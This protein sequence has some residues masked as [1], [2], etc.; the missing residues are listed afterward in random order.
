MYNVYMW[1]LFSTPA[2]YA[3]AINGVLLLIALVV[4]VRAYP[5]LSTNEVLVA[6]LLGSIA[7]G[8]HGISHV[9]V[10]GLLRQIE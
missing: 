8:I 4:F 2:F 6:T 1:L 5:R 3:H 7:V 9:E 10:G